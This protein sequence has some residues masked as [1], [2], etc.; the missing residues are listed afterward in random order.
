QEEGEAAG[1]V[2]SYIDV[3]AR[4]QP[5]GQRVAVV[6]AGGIGFDIAHYLAS[7]AHSTATDL[8][9]WQSEWGV[10]DPALVR[11]GLQAAQPLPPMREVTLLQRKPTPVGKGLGK[12][13]GWIHRAELRMRHVKMLAGVNYERIDAQG[14]HISY[15][16]QREHATL[17]AVDHIILCT[18]QEPLR[19]LQADLL[20]AGVATYLIGGADVA[21]ELDAKRAIAQGSALAA[22]L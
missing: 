19:T 6:G 15:G 12:T 1:M 11:G 2:L 22:R 14:L 7:G 9:A 20:A 3:L 8:A 18:G 16:P 13:T 17:I 4:Q 5:V 21:A 10:A